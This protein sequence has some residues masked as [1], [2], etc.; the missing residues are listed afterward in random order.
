MPILVSN[1]PWV[2]GDHDPIATVA[3][4]LELA[5]DEVLSVR[6][7]K[8]SLDARHKKPNWRAVYRAELRDEEAVLASSVASVRR[9]TLRDEGRYGFADGAPVKVR[10]WPAEYRPIVVGAG[11]AGLFASLFLAEAGAPVT[12]IE[13]GGPVE[14]RVRAVN[15]HWRGRL[16]FSEENNLVFGEGGAGTFS[17]GKIYTR[18]RDGEL[19]FVFRRLV[20]FGA[21]PDVMRE[22]WAHLGTDKIRAILPPMRRRLQ[23]LGVEVRFHT[24]VTGLRI[25]DGVC[26]GVELSNG[27][28]IAGDAVFMAVGHSAR[29]SLRMMVEAGLDASARKIAVGARVE[30]PQHVVNLARYGE[31]HDTDL[32]PASYRLTYSPEGKRRA[33]TFCM[34]PGG[35]VVPA[36]NH[37]ERVVVNGMS[38]AAR[39]SYWANSAVI[40]EVSPSDFVADLPDADPEDPCIGFDWQ[41]RIERAAYAMG[42][43]GDRAPAQRVADYLENRNGGELPKTS[44]PLGVSSADLRE[45]F[46]ESLHTPLAEALRS[47][48]QDVPGFT[49]EEGVLIAP[50][51]RTT[52]PVQFTRDDLQQSTSVRGVFPIGE[53][54]GYAGGIVSSALDGLRAARGYLLARGLTE[55]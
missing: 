11:P 12:L 52:S 42:G 21:D 1:V 9:W 7:V 8:K 17:D 38:F 43:S 30:H 51:T 32:P 55:P 54:A 24:R 14:D 5:P 19:G 20:D 15:G 25:D 34:C 40:V 44:Y 3:R 4:C 29:D 37:V 35:M 16:A 33:H 46:P 18:R 27:N 49:G 26:R 28:T 13:R 31:E 41:D 53:G 10:D 45:L 39:G 23:E 36:S 48:N 2:E 47:F 6:L 50:E 22:S